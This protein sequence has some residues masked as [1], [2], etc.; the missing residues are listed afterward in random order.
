MSLE[1]TVTAPDALLVGLRESDLDPDPIEQFRRWYR[2]AEEAQQPQ[3]EGMALATTTPDGAP[4][5]RMVLLKGVDALGFVFFTNYD[6]RKGAELAANPRAALLFY[7]QCLSRQVRIEGPIERVSRAE[8]EAYYRTRPRD[9]RLGAWA[10]RQSAVIPNR[11][12]LDRRLA[13]LAEQYPDDNVPLPPY[14]GGFRV[15]PDSLEFW[16]SRPNRLHDRLRYVRRA[17]DSWR[18]ERLSP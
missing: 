9:A 8:S 7:W 10:S 13:E 16:Q 6:S 2:A 15:L 12:V 17:D 14:W 4:S 5:L 11:D 1:P 18:V 3:P